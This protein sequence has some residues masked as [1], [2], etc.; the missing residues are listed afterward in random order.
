[1]V[2]GDGFRIGASTEDIAP[3]SPEPTPEFESVLLIAEEPTPTTEHDDPKHDPD[4][5]AAPV[6]NALPVH[7]VAD[8]TV[9]TPV[10]N[11][12]AAVAPVPVPDGVVAPVMVDGTSCK[13]GHFN[14]PRVRFCAQCG[15]GMVQQ[16]LNLVSGERP[17]LGVLVLDDG[18]TFLLD[19]D[20]VVG[21]EPTLD[22][23]VLAGR[24]RPLVVTDATEIVSR[25]HLGVRLS[26]WDVT[27]C[28]R[29]SANGSTI[30][31]PDTADSVALTP[32]EP[33]VIQPGTTVALGRQRTFVFESHRRP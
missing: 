4:P 32:Y 19:G 13:R 15:I 22:G 25:S 18:A 23:D 31:S 6:T 3:S 29:G 11:A 8:E 1:V 33:V 21:R 7:D 28:D 12:P 20:Y 9:S 24:A 26:G 30:R 27:V 14:D 17:S 16:T 10:P 5:P 2:P